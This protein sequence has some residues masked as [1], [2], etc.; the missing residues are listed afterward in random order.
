[1]KVRT[2]LLVEGLAN[3]V[4]AA[5]KFV[6]GLYTGST[7]ILG[8]ALHSL[9]DLAN[10]V[11][12]FIVARIAEQPPDHDHPYGHQK[13]EPLAVFVLA[14]LLVVVA[15]ELVS[16][17]LGR[18]GEAPR[19]DAQ[20]LLVMGATLLINVVVTLWEHRWARRLGS[21]LLLAD[22]RHTLGDVLVTA[23]VIA[24]WQLAVH[25]APWLDSLCAL[26]VAGLV[27]Y[28]AYDLFRRAVPVLVDSA[29]YD[30]GQ[31]AAAVRTV[32][33]VLAVPR[34]RSR[35]Q[36][37]TLVA[38]VVLKVDG[39]L[40]THEAHAIADAVEQLLAARFGIQDTTV[41]I[42]PAEGK[43]SSAPAGRR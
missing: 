18:F 11:I 13:F 34:V 33:G 10:N 6:V 21:D 23:S 5:T 32:P 26:L 42:E 36:G 41:H 12:A 25:V 28:L 1:M 29:A 2:V 16:R 30:G 27:A 35:R 24:G 31:L 39:A 8:D 38:D 43:S 4:L 40:S 14:G 20:A 3:A 9:T 17:A 19:H 22:A 7:A 37:S 15:F